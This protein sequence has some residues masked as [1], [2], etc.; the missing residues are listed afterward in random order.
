VEPRE[1]KRKACFGLYIVQGFTCFLTA[2]FEAVCPLYA[3]FF[4]GG[5]FQKQGLVL[6]F[7][8]HLSGL[9]AAFQERT[10]A[11]M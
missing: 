7:F 1:G 2:S 9:A 8:Y 5:R 6:M 10:V 3:Y 11:N 4:G